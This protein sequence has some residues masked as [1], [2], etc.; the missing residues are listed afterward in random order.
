MKF[1]QL[2]ECS[3]I[4][5]FLEKSYIKCGEETSPKP[6][7][8]KLK[9]SIPLDQQPKVY[10]DHLLLPKVYTDHLLLYRPFAVADH[11]LLPHI[12]QFKKIKRG[13]ELVSLPHFLHNFLEKFFSCYILITDQVSQSSCLY[14]VRYWTICVMKLFVNQ[15]VTSRIFKLTLSF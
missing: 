3:M 4:N 13:L 7:Y 10:T 12:K 9:L 11:L 6:F 5:I 15:V 14:F 8:E 2:I 1:G